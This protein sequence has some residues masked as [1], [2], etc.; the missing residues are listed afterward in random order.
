[1]GKCPVGGRVRRGDGDA[2]AWFYFE[3]DAE[4]G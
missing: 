3:V 1:M 2:L 4:A